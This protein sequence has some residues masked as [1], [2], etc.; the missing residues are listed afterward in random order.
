MTAFDCGNHAPCSEESYFDWFHWKIN[1]FEFI[2][3]GEIVS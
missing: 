2:F 1:E 3:V